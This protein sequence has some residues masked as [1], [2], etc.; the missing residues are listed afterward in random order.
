MANTI[1]P[2]RAWEHYKPDAA[3]P[4]DLQEGRPP[5]PPG[6]LRVDLEGTPG[7]R[8]RLART[9]S[10]T[11]CSRAATHPRS[12]TRIRTSSCPR[13]PEEVQHRAAGVRLVAL[14]D[15]AR[16][17]PAPRKAHA[18][19][20]QPLRDVERQGPERRLHGRPV[21]ADAPARPGQLRRPAAGDVQGP[22]HDGLAGHGA[23][24]RRA[25]RTRTMPAS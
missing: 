22:G 7:R 6:R 3:N 11:N 19:L 17:A 2:R 13:P 14:S 20:A 16:R 12:T 4:W 21:R 8:S 25:S 24:A 10:S 1:D 5:L 18:V 9:S 15:A 23:R